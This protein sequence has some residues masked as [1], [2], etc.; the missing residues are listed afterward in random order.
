MEF[1]SKSEHS[2]YLVCF[3]TGLNHSNIKF[4]HSGDQSAE[5]FLR[6][7]S[8]IAVYLADTFSA[9]YGELI[10]NAVLAPTQPQPLEYVWEN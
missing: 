2:N 10:L 9:F 3:Y 7:H 4:T 8:C 1:A 6:T 5:I